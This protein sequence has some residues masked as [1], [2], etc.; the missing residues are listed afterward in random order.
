MRVLSLNCRGLRNQATVN[1]LHG[2]VKLEVPQIVFLMETRLPVQKLEF[3]RVK[4]GMR[5]CF[6]VNRKRFGGRLALFWDACVTLHVQ[7]YSL[8]CID[9][10]VFQDDGVTW[11][12]TGFYGPPETGIRTRSW[13]LLRQ[14]HAL[15]D[16]P[17]VLL[18]DF[19]EIVALEEKY[20]MEDRSL[21]QMAGFWEVLS[22]CS[23]LDLGFIGSEFTWSNNREDEALVR[24]RLDHGVATQNWKALFPNATVSHLTVVNS[25]H[26]GL[27]MDMAPCPLQPRRKKHKLFWFDHTWVQE[28]G[29][30]GVITEAW[31]ADC[32]GTPMFRLVHKIKQCRLHL[33]QWSQSHV[34]ATPRLIEKKKCQ[35]QALEKQSPACYNAQDV[36]VVRH[37]L[38]GLMKQ[39]ETFWR[40]RSRVAWLHGGDN[41]T[42]YFHECASQ[43]K[44]TNTIHGLR[45]SN[46]IWQTEPRVMEST[47]VEYFQT[48]FL[49]SKPTHIAPVTQ[50]VDEVVTQDMHSKLLHPITTEEVKC[51][52]F[53]M[54]P[55]KAPRPDGMTALFFQKYWH[56]VGLHVTDVVLDCLNSVRML[57]CLNFTNA[58]PKGQS[59]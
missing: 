16:W 35:L 2:L 36:N 4:F 6:G 17:W 23:L 34:K 24:V 26:M 9:A 31:Q 38:C 18:G 37:K 56:I 58:Y 42:K 52:L 43:R 54:H 25:D 28:E 19:N 1:E 55:S 32:V 51:A 5:G 39:E 30:E 33:I 10:H 21:R 13:A 40:Q 3:L 44:K 48:L 7:S 47:A 11:R 49:S 14:L 15:A 27:L 20:G 46:Q 45:D 53:Q 8:F 59:S 29:C 41:N 22:D 57:G 12:F 50:L